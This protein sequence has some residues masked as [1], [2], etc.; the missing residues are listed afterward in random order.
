LRALAAAIAWICVAGLAL[1][2]CG[3]NGSGQP[4]RGAGP[5]IAVPLR[6]A[7]CTDWSRADT[8]ERLGTIHALTGFAGGPIG[9]S[10]IEHGRVLTDKQAYGLLQRFCSE[11]YARGFKLYKI[12]ER[13]AAFQGR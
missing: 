5:S 9:S 13:G 1:A 4:P 8:A 12:Y 2:G 7:N 10:P 3:G 6:S 11:P